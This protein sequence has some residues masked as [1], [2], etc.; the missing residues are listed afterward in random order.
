M[1]GLKNSR[2][3]LFAV[4]MVAPGLVLAARAAFADG[5][6]NVQP[7]KAKPHGYSLT[8][9]A[10]AIALFSTSGNNSQYY[11]DTPFQLLYEDT[12]YDRGHPRRW[13]DRGNRKQQLHR[14]L[15]D[16]VLRAGRLPGRLAALLRDFPRR[17]IRGP[18]VCLRSA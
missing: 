10:S 5:G 3:I 13:W 8:D 15:R 12:S 9:M 1:T 16:T 4:I 18:C 14:P 2:R 6:G 17:C 7:P 11:P